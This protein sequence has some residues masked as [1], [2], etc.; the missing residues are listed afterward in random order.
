MVRFTDGTGRSQF[1]PTCAVASAAGFANANGTSPYVDVEGLLLTSL[2]TRTVG[3]AAGLETGKATVNPVQ[4]VMWEIQSSGAVGASADAGAAP[5]D[6]AR[7]NLVRTFLNVR[8]DAVGT[9]EVIAEYA[10]DLRF[11]FSVAEDLTTD[12][13]TTRSLTV[14]PI[15]HANNSLWGFDP[16]G[17]PISL[18]GPQRIRSIHVRLATR[19]SFADRSGNL[20]APTD[21]LYRYCIDPAA[22]L[23]SC[24]QFARVRTVTTEIALPNQA[25]MFY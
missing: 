23:P 2:D 4:W 9:P 13:G 7:F 20:A 5:G 24:R 15:G 19:T 12:A 6:R 21:Y 25:G 11:G 3:G 8:K 16:A 10:V 18:R 14:I 22:A 1:L 17:L